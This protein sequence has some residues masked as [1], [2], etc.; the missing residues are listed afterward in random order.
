M[1]D[2]ARINGNARIT[3]N[4]VVDG[5]M[6][7]YARS[8]LAQ[9][10]NEPFVIPWEAFRVHDALATNLPGTPATD[11]LG[12][13]GGTFGS[14]S[15]KISTGDVKAAGCTRYARFQFGL[16]PEYVDG[17]TITLRLHAGMTT[18]VADGSAT[19]DVEA[20][21]SDG[22]AGVGSDICA[23][24]AQSINS[25]TMADKDFIITPTGVSAGDVLD[26]RLTIAVADSATVTAVIADVTAATMLVDIQG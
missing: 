5:V 13:V 7:T 19:L 2:A 24:A 3:G 15:P 4:L 21:Q 12:L 9:D 1:T 8:N 14:A 16:P 25:L 6:P 23:T 26:I 18:T 10:N 20:Y 11:D 22:E 17:Q